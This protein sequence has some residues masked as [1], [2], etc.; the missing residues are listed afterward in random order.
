MLELAD[1]L[2]NSQ[3]GFAERLGSV[4][5]IVIW[6]GF[7]SVW[8]KKCISTFIYSTTLHEFIG[9]RQVNDGEK[10]LSLLMYM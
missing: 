6:C 7:Y 5:N 10:I 1:E 3:F 8:K 2:Q 4:L 9:K